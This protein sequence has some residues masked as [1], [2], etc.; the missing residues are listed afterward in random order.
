MSAISVTRLK[1]DSSES[2]YGRSSGL[3][4]LR[5]DRSYIHCQSHDLKTSGNDTHSITAHDKVGIWQVWQPSLGQKLFLD[6]H[7]NFLLNQWMSVLLMH[8]RIQRHAPSQLHT[9]LSKRTRC[10][11]L[12]SRAHFLTQMNKEQGTNMQ[13]RSWRGYQTPCLPHHSTT[14]TMSMSNERCG[15][16]ND[17]LIVLGISQPPSQLFMRRTDNQHV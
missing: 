8:N 17:P 11:F 4:S 9:R 2:W 14:Y 10:P 15:D 6:N 3:S 16:R 12:L 1:M 13:N 7:T 5:R